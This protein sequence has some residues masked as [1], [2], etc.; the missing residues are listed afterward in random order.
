MHS[1]YQ[2]FVMQTMQTSD[3]QKTADTLLLVARNANSVEMLGHVLWYAH[4]LLS[5][6]RLDAD[7]ILGSVENESGSGSINALRRKCAQLADPSNGKP[8]DDLREVVRLCVCILRQEH[9]I[10]LVECYRQSIAYLS[11]SGRLSP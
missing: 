4:A 3:Y 8:A 11:Q 2:A 5:L 1:D 6:L 10:P 7:W 9:S